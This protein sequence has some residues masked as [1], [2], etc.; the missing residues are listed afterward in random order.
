MNKRPPYFEV[1][2]VCILQPPHP[3]AKHFW[4]QETTVQRVIWRDYKEYDAMGGFGPGYSYETDIPAPP[5][6]DDDKY[7]DVN[8]LWCEY[9]L[10]KKYKPGDSIEETLEQLEDVLILEE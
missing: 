5:I 8:W 4:G 3:S 1:G 6:S 7:K 10:K 2:E 9:D